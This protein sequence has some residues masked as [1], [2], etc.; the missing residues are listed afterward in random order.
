MIASIVIPTFNHAGYVAAA[1]DS[2]L[3]QT[4]PCEVV[5]VDDGSTDSTNS[6]LARYAG[7]IKAIALPHGG[8]ATARNAGL[9]EAA[10]EFVMFL[11]ADDVIEPDKISAQ[12]AEFDE[13][14]DAGWV[15][16]DVRIE[17]ANSGRVQLASERY[18]YA[19]K[20]QDAWLQP[21]LTAA[22]FIPIMA[23]LVRREVIGDIRFPTD[24]ATEDWHFW[25][26]IAG[27]ARS[28]YLPRVLAT[29]R[30]HASGRNVSSR[31][32]PSLRPGVAGPLRLNLGCG[33][34][35]TRSWHP[36]PGLV[37][38]DRSL[39]WKFEDGLGDFAD[40]S[41][42]GISISHAMM[43]VALEHWPR[44]FAEFARVL[45]RGGVLR[46]TED[47]ATNPASPRLG[48][49]KGSEPAVAITGP[50]MVRH[51][52]ELVG[53]TVHEVTADSSYFP[54]RSLCQ[55]QHGAPP[56]VFWIEGV[57]EC[58][59]LLSPHADDETLFAA[60]TIIRHRPRVVVCCP[61]SGDYGDT[62]TRTAETREAVAI[63]GGG[64]VEQWDGNDLEAKMRALDARIRPS[65]AW[66]PSPDTS[67]PDHLTVALVAAA[68][69]GDRLTRYQ[70]YDI[71]AGGKVRA[72]DP[73]P[74]DA[75]WPDLKRR[76]LACYR[77][78][79]EHPRAREFFAWDLAEYA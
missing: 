3:A 68:V 18:D 19:E 4:V 55:A 7:R 42:A 43:Y 73:V 5:V 53:F 78:Q 31:L 39:G 8:P 25:H 71:N 30:K 45:Q 57:R 13:N 44:V 51:Y 32:D 20:M 29:Y 26:D 40:G 38:L 69:F 52:M 22:N 41:V 61:S 48:G 50:A 77:T 16:C 76:A 74:F 34:P 72:G 49:W 15:L 65:R 46:I 6:V 60:F 2:A 63:L 12:L 47:D 67:H 10:G 24:R 54:D 27:V 58:S 75:G 62:A 9:E 11:D 56:D 21:L 36:M 70:T 17:E 79:I 28:R 14:H 33:T 59:V 37:N 66:A 1:I 35:G 23:P 64:P